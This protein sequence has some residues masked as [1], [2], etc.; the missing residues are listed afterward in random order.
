MFMVN[1][2]A[3]WRLGEVQAYV[4]VV[5]Q[6]TQAW[7]V[8]VCR[9]ETTTSNALMAKAWAIWVGCDLA[10]RRH[11]NRIIVESDSKLA[12]SYLVDGLVCTL[13]EKFCPS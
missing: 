10:R 6:D 8:E 7:C 1:V 3:R 2:D 13:K 11:F 4:G 5:I 9:R 12:I